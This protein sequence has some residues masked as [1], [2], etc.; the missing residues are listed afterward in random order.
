LASKWYALV[1][2]ANKER[3]LWR[4]FLAD[5][6]DVF[7]PRISNGSKKPRPKAF[8]PRY[9]FIRLD[10]ETVGLSKINSIPY[11]NGLVSMGGKP[12]HIPDV[13]IEA[14]RKRVEEINASQ[15]EPVKN[16]TAAG[17]G[18][19]SNLEVLLNSDKPEAERLEILKRINQE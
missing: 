5:G 13:M 10:L 14:I 19:F 16:F 17:N 2:K 1:C 12:F 4:K 8:F 9:I 18:L 7:Y 15:Q 11:T 6:F 3:F